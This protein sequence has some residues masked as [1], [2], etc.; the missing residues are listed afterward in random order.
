MEG[1]RYRRMLRKVFFQAMV[2]I[3]DFSASLVRST[4][5]SSPRVKRST[6]FSSSVRESVIVR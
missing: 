2:S 1:D 3:S 4:L 6:V 5:P